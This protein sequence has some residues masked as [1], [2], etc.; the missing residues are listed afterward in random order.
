M[1]D[2]LRV[3]HRLNVDAHV[4]LL[5]SNRVLVSWALERSFIKPGPYRFELQRGY[6]ANDENFQTVAAVVDQPWAYDNTPVFPKKGIDV[7]YRVKLTDGN[8][9]TYFSQSATLSCYW[10]RYDW[11][12]ARDIV[13]KEALLLQRRAGVK[14]WLLK[15]RV[16]GD[17]CVACTDPVTHQINDANCTSCYGT[18]IV[19]GYYAPIEYWVIVN[20]AQRIQ[21]IFPDVGIVSETKQTI[22]ALAYPFPTTND[23]WVQAYTDQRYVIQGDIVHVAI[24]RGINLVDNLAIKELPRSDVVY[25][26]AWC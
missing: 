10:N 21:R 22:R 16:W 5:T 19:G 20:P 1:V 23:I 14:G 18:G 24:H 11:T 7:F 4:T 9:D 12:I 6:A 25:K 26:I 17:L 2:E 8:S 13:R 15:R 3:F